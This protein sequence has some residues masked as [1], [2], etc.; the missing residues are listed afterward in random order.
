MTEEELQQKLDK[1]K[2]VADLAY[3]EWING[4]SDDWR[5]ARIDH[6]IWISCIRRYNALKSNYQRWRLNKTGHKRET[7]E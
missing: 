2:L 7:N 6:E 4:G 3:D 5:I 1:A